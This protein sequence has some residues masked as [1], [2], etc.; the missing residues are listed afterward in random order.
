MLAPLH[1]RLLNDYQQD[2]PLSPTPYRD[3]AEQLGVSEDEVLNAFQT[4]SEQQMISRIGPVIA[5]NSIGNSALVAMAVP[6][7]D[8]PRVAELVSAYPEVNHNY[9]REN[10]F[11]LWFVLIADSEAHLK[12]VIADIETQ[13]GYPAMLLPMLADYFINLGFELNL[14]D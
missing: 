9:E 3:I 11:N 5:P 8:L 2:F 4:L 13:T 6:E 14:H 12:G 10:R 7:F 1:K